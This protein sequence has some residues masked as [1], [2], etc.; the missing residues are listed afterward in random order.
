MPKTFFFFEGK[1]NLLQRFILNFIHHTQSQS[2]NK[3]IVSWGDKMK[4]SAM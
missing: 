4:C 3:K 2:L 1:Q